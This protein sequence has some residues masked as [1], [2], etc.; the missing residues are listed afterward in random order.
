MSEFDDILD[1]NGNFTDEAVKQL[2]SVKQQHNQ[3]NTSDNILDSRKTLLNNANKTLKRTGTLK[4]DA[5]LYLRTLSI[6][7]F[8]YR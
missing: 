1:M 5:T 3:D 8:I 6:I 2:K 4:K 7:Y